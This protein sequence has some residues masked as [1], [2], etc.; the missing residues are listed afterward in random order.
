VVGVP[1]ATR[2][3]QLVGWRAAFVIVA[4][5]GVAT[6]ILARITLAPMPAADGA[7][8]LTELGAL[9]RL[10]VWLTLGIAAIGFGGMF[11][12]YSYITPTVVH[13]TGRSEAAVPALL[14]ACGFGMIAGSLFGGW[15]ADRGILRAIG[16]VIVF[17]TFVLAA[18]AWSAHSY[19]AL[20][21]NMFLVG[22]AGLAMGPAIQTRL[23]DVAADAQALAAALNHSAF[24]L[25][26][27]LGAWLGGLAIAH[28][29]GYTSTGPIGAGLCAAGF[30]V[31]LV[32]L[33]VARRRSS[34]V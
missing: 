14:A 28:G 17:D 31:Y 34:L 33:V 27:A 30:V 29:L 2:V 11:A 10:E 1:L 25:A 23:M 19:P 8:P 12:V 16:L 4:G 22:F 18:F 9:K 26:N 20:M 5:L 21:V 3:G 15:L 6:A 7:T 32:A 13:V 24:N